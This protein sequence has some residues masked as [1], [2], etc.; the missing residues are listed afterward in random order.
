MVDKISGVENF[1]I[2]GFIWQTSTALRFLMLHHCLKCSKHT[3][4]TTKSYW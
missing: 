4:R 1:H 3:F 2:I